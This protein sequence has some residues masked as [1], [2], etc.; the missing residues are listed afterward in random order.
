[1]KKLIILLVLSLFLI[2]IVKITYNNCTKN[3]TK[4]VNILEWITTPEEII[5]NVKFIN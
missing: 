3:R 5:E 2:P 1:M 4:I